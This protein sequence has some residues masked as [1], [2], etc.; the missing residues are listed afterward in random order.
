M[1]ETFDG[2]ELTD[3]DYDPRLT[4][5]TND[6][7]NAVGRRV[8]TMETE[9][10]SGAVYLVDDYAVVRWTDYVAGDWAE[11]YTGANRVAVAVARLAVLALPA[12]GSHL[13]TDDADGFAARAEPVLLGSVGLSADDA[14]PECSGSGWVAVTSP[15]I[16]T[17]SDGCD[18]PHPTETVT[19][20]HACDADGCDSGWTV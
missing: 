11:A 5:G 17:T 9:T 3:S 13:F 6:D 19:V 18:E 4:R 2:W 7:A 12:I 1:T 14:C 8:A 16:R 20:L 10:V 15:A